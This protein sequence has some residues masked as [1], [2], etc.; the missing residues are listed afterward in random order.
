MFKDAMT[1]TA[2]SRIGLLI[3]MLCC[4]IIGVMCYWYPIFVDQAFDKDA[5]SRIGFVIFSFLP[6]LLAAGARAMWDFWRLLRVLSATERNGNVACG[7]TAAFL[8]MISLSPLA[9]I[10]LNLLR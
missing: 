1:L 9:I 7:L 2:D 6:I 10:A 3:W 8:L 5:D 4:A